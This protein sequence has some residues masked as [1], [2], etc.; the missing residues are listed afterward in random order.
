[1][2]RIGFFLLVLVLSVACSTVRP[3]E[4]G[5][6]QS[7]GKLKGE[8]QGPGVVGHWPIFAKVVRVPIRSTKLEVE[9]PLPSREGLTVDAELSI[10]YRVR[11]DSIRQIL[12]EIGLDYESAVVLTTFRS[13]AANV[14]SQHAAKDMHSGAR[15]QIEGEIELRLKDLLGPRG[16]EIEA[17]L[18]KSIRLPDSLSQA[19]QAKLAAEQAAQQMT[20]VLQTERLE[21]DRLRVEA[22]GVRD[23]QRI[24][25]QGLTPLLIQWKAIEA[26]R[27]LAES[28]NSKIIFTDGR[29]PLLLPPSVQEDD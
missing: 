7:M 20:F 13:A 27:E 16:F 17:V 29:S 1:M 19:I 23:A 8:P 12:E 25:D 6:R 4:R 24:V 9:L 2:A 14:S 10:L 3:G 18:L 15:A 21:A 28:P 5:I 22:E 11:E 26:F